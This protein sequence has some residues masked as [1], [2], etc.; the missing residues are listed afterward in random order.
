MT[1][2]AAVIDL[3]SFETTLVNAGH[4]LVLRHRASRAGVHELGG[5]IAGLPLAVLADTYDEL[6][7]K[8]EPGDTLL[9][10]TDGEGRG[11]EI[12]GTRCMG[13]AS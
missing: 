5:D 8:L 10:Y 3:E 7:V 12:R 11:P 4:P 13:W 2:V 6:V 9:L 1:F